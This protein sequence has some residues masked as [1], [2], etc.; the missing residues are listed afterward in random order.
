[1]MPDVRCY[2]KPLV[3]LI[4]TKA[5]DNIARERKLTPEERKEQKQYAKLA[6]SFIPR[7]Q[8]V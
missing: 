3:T 2:T 6:D 1:M 4:F 5:L 8:K 7:W